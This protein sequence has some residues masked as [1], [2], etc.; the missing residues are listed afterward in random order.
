MIAFSDL[1]ELAHDYESG[2]LLWRDAYLSLLHLLASHDVEQVAAA[3][4]PALAA[5]FEET[6][7]AEF[8]DE[9]WATDGLWI[10]SAGGEPSNLREI[11]GRIR[12]WLQKDTI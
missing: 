9:R 3:L 4:S 2:N 8:S 12:A 11:V 5:R 1:P 6:L 7:R 10:D